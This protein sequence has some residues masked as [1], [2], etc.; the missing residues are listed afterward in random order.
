MARD[1]KYLGKI[2]RET[3]L[4]RSYVW[5]EISDFASQSASHISDPNSVFCWDR[6]HGF[7]IV[8]LKGDDIL[9]C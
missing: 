8:G 7:V 5:P 1:E 9:S 6:F 2:H 4:K 3:S